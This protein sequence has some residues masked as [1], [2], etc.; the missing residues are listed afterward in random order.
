MRGTSLGSIGATTESKGGADRTTTVSGKAAW[1]K[2]RRNKSE[3]GY[4]TGT[5]AG[6]LRHVRAE[7]TGFL[8]D[9]VAGL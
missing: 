7:A 4:R 1:T 5:K 8:R 2:G 9:R 6:K 3:K